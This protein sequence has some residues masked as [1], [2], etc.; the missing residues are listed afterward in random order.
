[1]PKRQEIWG[2]NLPGTPWATS[3]CRGGRLLYLAFSSQIKG[4]LLKLVNNYDYEAIMAKQ[5]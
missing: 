1:V 4:I 2:L 5:I 3:A